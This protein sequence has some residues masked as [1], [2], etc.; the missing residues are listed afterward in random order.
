M[1]AERRLRQNAEV[2][3][4]AIECYLS[5][6]VRETG[7]VSLKY[8]SATTTGYPDRLLLY[9]GGV[10]VWVEVKSHGA[11]P[12]PLQSH[13]IA[14]LRGLG[15][16]AYVCDS[17]EKADEIVAAAMRKRAPGEGGSHEV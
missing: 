17:R 7:G 11:R 3:E 15:F 14:T 4:K 12:T 1:R 5:R 16:A 9:P 6:R 2:S 13:R 8:S 10:A